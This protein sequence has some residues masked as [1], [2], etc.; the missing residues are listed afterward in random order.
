MMDKIRY[1]CF[2]LRPGCNMTDVHP[3]CPSSCRELLPGLLIEDSTI[4]S[5]ASAC[6]R[7][8]FKGMIG[9][10]YYSE[11]MLDI[12]RIL[13]FMQRCPQYRYV[14]WTNGLLLTEQSRD[15]LECFE[16]VSISLYSQQEAIRIL[17]IINGLSNC[18]A[19]DAPHDRRIDLYDAEIQ[20]PG[21]CIRPRTIE[22]PVDAWGRLHLCCS[23]YDA[24]VDIASI[25]TDDH[26][27]CINRYLQEAQ[28]AA[29]GQQTLCWKCR[30][31]HSPC[32]GA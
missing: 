19:N 14:L 8:G 11:P 26:D 30:T 15:W 1:L 32:I 22:I 6:T 21:G 2:E 28:R 31:I 27:Y 16:Q 25:V 9:F 20:S 12:D 29:V 18:V 5:F 7:R 17:P 13:A 3:W 23:D 4:E 24:H 10:H